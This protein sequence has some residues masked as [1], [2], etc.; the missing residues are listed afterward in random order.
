VVCKPDGRLRKEGRSLK[1]D[2]VP[3]NFRLV[4]LPVFPTLVV[5]IL[6][7]PDTGSHLRV[8]CLLTPL[9]CLPLG[10]CQ[11]AQATGDGSRL[12]IPLQRSCYLSACVPLFPPLVFTYRV[13]PGLRGWS[14]TN[15]ARL[16]RLDASLWRGRLRWLNYSVSKVQNVLEHKF[17]LTFQHGMMFF[18]VLQTHL[19]LCDYEYACL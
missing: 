13:Q 10:S 11:D 6:D 2:R 12:L 8:S 9:V 16:G 18:L 4:L 5:F 17:F 3:L 14:E 1:K 15:L 19:R 7:N